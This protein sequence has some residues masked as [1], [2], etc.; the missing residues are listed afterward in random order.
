MCLLFLL[1]I[2]KEAIAKEKSWLE[3]IKNAKGNTEANSLKQTERINQTG[4]FD[5]GLRTENLN[6][7]PVYMI[8]L[9]FYFKWNLSIWSINSR[10]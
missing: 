4:I 5:F 8:Y 3:E 6:G 1:W 7:S 9:Y 2:Q 10:F